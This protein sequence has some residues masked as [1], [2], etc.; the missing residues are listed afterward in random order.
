MSISRCPGWLST[1]FL[2]ALLDI[3]AGRAYTDLHQQ[4]IVRSGKQGM[5]GDALGNPRYFNQTSWRTLEVLNILSLT[6]GGLT[7]AEMADKLDC[8][9]SSLYPILKTMELARF[10]AAD[11]DNS[12]YV[13]TPRIY[14]IVRQ[15]GS[16]QSLTR[17][18]EAVSRVAVDEAQETMQMAVLDGLD[19]VY[20]AKCESNQSVRLASDVG[21]RLPSYATALG[22]CL[23][24]ALEPEH[25]ERLFA[26][27]AMPPL[28][29]RTVSNVAALL[30]TLTKV[31]ADGVAEDWQEVSDGLCCVSAPVLDGAGETVAAVS[32]SV[33]LHRAEPGRWS[34][35]RRQILDAAQEMS[36]QLGY[37]QVRDVSVVGA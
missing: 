16:K 3:R 1:V 34:K 26:D 37:S 4:M 33:P 12:R 10:I 31:R 19:V 14:E 17:V 7:L 8:S 25:V 32:F 13:L 29:T 23:L 5:E 35:L 28:T 11:A 2:G 20:V 21:R 22:K 18:F 15:H 27:Q 9:K 6:E 24:A 30:S 36:R